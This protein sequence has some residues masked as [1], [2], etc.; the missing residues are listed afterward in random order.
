MSKRD[1]YEILGVS[2]TATEVELKSSFRKLAMQHHPDKNPGDVQAEI[3]FKEINEAYQVL[4]DG[5]K[6]ALYDRHGHA[7]FE[8]GG[9]GG[10]NPDFS[11]FMSDIFDSF[12]GDSRRAGP[13]GANGR[14]RGADGPRRPGPEGLVRRRRQPGRGERGGGGRRRHRGVPHIFSGAETPSRSS[15]LR[16]TWAAAVFSHRR[17]RCRSP[18]S[19]G[20]P[21]SAGTGVMR[22][23][24]YQEW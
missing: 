11:D 18:T 14:E 13:R 24:A 9:G 8:Q 4:S 17:V 23:A 19:P 20:A 16:S 6:R 2:R 10:G 7:A 3:K 1:Y 15:P 21:S 5:Q 22:H 12:F